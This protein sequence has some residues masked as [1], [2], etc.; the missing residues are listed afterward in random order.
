MKK[1]VLIYLAILGGFFVLLFSLD[2]KGEFTVEKKLWSINKEYHKIVQDPNVVPDQMFKSV[3]DA[4][5][6][7]IKAYPKSALVENVHFMVADLYVL[8]KDYAKARE[9]YDLM[10]QIYSD[11]RELIADI[12]AKIGKTYEAADDWDQA[13]KIYK[14]ATQDFP[15]TAVGLGLP[16]YIANY[17]KVK[18]DYQG[19][20]NA[21]NE[22]VA[23]YKEL[24]A[25]NA[26]TRLGFDAARSLANC[27]M[28]LGQWQAAVNTLKG[29]LFDY[30]DASYLT[31]QR[32]D[33]I[34][35]AINIICAYQMNNYDIAIDIYKEFIAAHPDHGLNA[36]LERMIADFNKLKEKGIVV[37]PYKEK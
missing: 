16:M 14:Q 21:Y 25:K 30:S 19:M 18:K 10:I 17:Y 3:V 5:E 11:N 32:A 4:Y 9:K 31:P 13:E 35:K 33:N 1:I 15:E 24:V 26:S 20:V 8:K 2:S 28:E 12:R 7:L 34:L 6:A 27:Y 37:A 23:Y 29:V 36:Y 22:A